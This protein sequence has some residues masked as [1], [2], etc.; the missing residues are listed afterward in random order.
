MSVNEA[1]T[2]LSFYSEKDNLSK[3]KNELSKIKIEKIKSSI[4]EFS[5]PVIIRYK[6]KQDSKL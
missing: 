6:L 3:I 1:E 2:V 5:N 4:N